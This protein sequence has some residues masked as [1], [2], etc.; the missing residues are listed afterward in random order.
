MIDYNNNNSRC[1]R[2]KEWSEKLDLP[3]LFIFLGT[4]LAL[5]LAFFFDKLNPLYV[6][7]GDSLSQ[8]PHPDKETVPALILLVVLIVVPL[9]IFIVFYFSSKKLPDFFRTFNIWAVIWTLLTSQMAVQ[10]VTELL[11]TYVGRARPDMYA[12]CGENAQYETCKAT[13]SIL[14]DSFK[15]FPSGHA[16]GSFGA[17]YFTAMF[18][19]KV[20]TSRSVLVSYLALLFALLGLWVGSTRIRDF[21]HHPDDVVAGFFVGY[22]VTKLIWKNAKDRIFPKSTTTTI[23]IKQNLIEEV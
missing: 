19:M 23:S 8:F 5:G 11:K 7:I 3:D 9:V 1:T 6:P 4:L 21:R 17:M 15:S 13:G 22:V 16:S 2:F 10:L 12:R 20:F 18:I 14:S